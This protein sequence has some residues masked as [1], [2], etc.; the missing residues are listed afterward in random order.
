MLVSKTL[1]SRVAIIVF[2]PLN[3]APGSSVRSV[4][5]RVAASIPVNKIAVYID[6]TVFNLPNTL[7]K[8]QFNYLKQAIYIS[9]ICKRLCVNFFII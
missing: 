2:V 5:A 3:Y 1:R 4:S 9:V 8:S 7:Q 6:F